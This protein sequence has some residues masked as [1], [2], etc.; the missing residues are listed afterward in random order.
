MKPFLLTMTQERKEHISLM[1][2]NIY[3]TFD[4]VIALVNLPSNDGTIELLQANKGNGKI[5]TQNWTPNHGFLMNHLLFYGGIQNGQY[6]IYLDSPESMTDLFIKELPQMLNDFNNNNIGA[7]YWDQRPY[8]FKYNPYMEF[9]GAV[10]WGLTNITGKIITL[11]EKDKYI[12]NRRKETPKYFGSI[13]GS[14]YYLCYFLGNDMQ[15]LYGKYGQDVVNHHEALRK[16]FQMYCVNVLKLNI[17]TLDDMI[18]YM[19]KIKNKEIAPDE[20]FVDM[21]ELEIR[22]SE[23]FQIEVLGQD[24]M[25]DVVPMRDRF[26]FKDY[27]A[28]NSGFPKDYLGTRLQYNRQFN[29][30]DD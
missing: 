22:L 9:Y 13:N 20:Y 29:I 12:I 21:V 4:G 24:F 8:I 11:P 10:H 1:L 14:K 6:C 25:K 19:K 18:N 23:L 30:K 15:L 7:L 27:L 16:K 17:S 2:K 5:I 3:P 26:S 28:G